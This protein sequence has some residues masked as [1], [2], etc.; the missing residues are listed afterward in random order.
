MN[1]LGSQINLEEHFSDGINVNFAII[2]DKR[3]FFIEHIP[4]WEHFLS[5]MKN[6]LNKVL[7]EL[8]KDIAQVDY[9]V[10]HNINFDNFKINKFYFVKI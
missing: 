7:T 9:I 1:F 6:K 4:Y 2:K 5:N 3:I 8:S 10:G